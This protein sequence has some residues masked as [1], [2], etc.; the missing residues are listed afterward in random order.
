MIK[1]GRYRKMVQES[2]QT[3]RQAERESLT[4]DRLLREL[5]RSSQALVQQANPLLDVL[6]PKKEVPERSS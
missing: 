2:Q 3:V 4:N 5:E 6:A 1:R